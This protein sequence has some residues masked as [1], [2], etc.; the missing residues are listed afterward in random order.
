[1]LGIYFSGTGNTKYCLERFLDYY[2]GSQPVSIES[3]NAIEAIRKSQ[4]IVFGYPIYY[5]NIPKIV[6]DYIY[7]NRV[8]FKNKRIFII[9]TMGL[10]SGDGAGCSARLLK[11]CGAN[12]VGGL[13]LK[14]PDCIGDVKLLKKPLAQNKQLIK[15][16][17][18][19]IENAVDLLKQGKPTKDGLNFFCHL[20]GLFGQRLWFY[21]KTKNYTNK[22]KINKSK[23]IGCGKCVTLCPM[24]NLSISKQKAISNNK[25]TMCYRCISHCPQKAITLLGEEVVEQSLIENYL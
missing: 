6:R 3:P 4:N 17:E 15:D 5:S 8:D 14:M 11:K 23:C 13:H 21:R 7:Q 19:K 10:F 18:I 20:A 9:C 16:A 1:M 12:I 2:D 22:L 24:S 25:C